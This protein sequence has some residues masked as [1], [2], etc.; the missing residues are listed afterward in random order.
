MRD[1]FYTILLIWI[2]WKVFNSITVYKTKQGAASKD[3]AQNNKSSEGQISYDK[4]PPSK[5]TINKDN[6]EYV[7]YEEIK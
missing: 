7:Y 1:V 3:Q 6:G 4:I 2:F 5:K